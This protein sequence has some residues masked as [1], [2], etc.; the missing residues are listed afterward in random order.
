MRSVGRACAAIQLVS[1]RLRHASS[2]PFTGARCPSLYS[3]WSATEER[4]AVEVRVPTKALTNPLTSEASESTPNSLRRPWKFTHSPKFPYSSPE[5][6]TAGLLDRLPEEALAQIASHGISNASP[7]QCLDILHAL[8][9]LGE[10]LLREKAVDTPTLRRVGAW[11]DDA[12]I[13]FEEDLGQGAGR[14]W[15]HHIQCWRFQSDCYKGALPEAWVYPSFNRRNTLM[16]RNGS[17]S[18]YYRALLACRAYGIDA[19]QVLHAVLREWDPSGEESNVELIQMAN[20]IIQESPKSFPGGPVTRTLELLANCRRGRSMLAFEVFQQMKRDGLKIC[21]ISRAR[22]VFA[23]VEDNCLSQAQEILSVT[24][25]SKEAGAWITQLEARLAF[26]AR[27]QD[28]G[29][30]G[31]T[32]EKVVKYAQNPKDHHISWLLEANIGED[33]RGKVFD[34]FDT[35][36][37][38]PSQRKPQAQHYTPLM[39]ALARRG[40]VS[41]LRGCLEDALRDGVRPDSAMFNAVLSA[42][43]ERQD[44]QGTSSVCLLMEEY[45]VRRTA[46]TY[47]ILVSMS[48]R[49]EG[50]STERV[51]VQAIEKGIELDEQLPNSV[52]HNLLRIGTRNGAPFQAILSFF[53][54]QLPLQGQSLAAQTYTSMIRAACEVGRMEDAAKLLKEYEDGAAGISQRVDWSPAVAVMT[55]YLEA[56]HYRRAH[57]VYNHMRAAGSPFNLELAQAAVTLCVAK[58]TEG[59]VLAAEHLLNEVLQGD[60][61]LKRA[62]LERVLLPLMQA[63]AE[64]LHP[65]DV[66]R[67]FQTLLRKGKPSIG[68]CSIQLDAYR[69]VGDI[70]SA[71]TCWQRIFDQAVEQRSLSSDKIAGTEKRALRPDLLGVPLN[72]ILDTLSLAGEHGELL[73]LWEEVMTS[74]FA[75]SIANRN[76]LIVALIRAGEPEQA[77]RVAEEIL[78]HPGV[79]SPRRVANPH[80]TC[81]D[82]TRF[83][84]NAESSTK[85]VPDVVSYGWKAPEV[86][87][88]A[89]IRARASGTSTRHISLGIHAATMMAMRNV[90]LR[91]QRGHIASAIKPGRLMPDEETRERAEASRVLASLRRDFP[92]AAHVASQKPNRYHRNRLAESDSKLGRNSDRRW[93]RRHERLAVPEEGPGTTSPGRA[94]QG[95]TRSRSQVKELLKTKMKT[96]I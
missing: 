90:L 9:F 2:G 11:M 76:S 95:R 22:L 33:G 82:S 93:W 45:G 70:T 28:A 52:L 24:G 13:Q 6:W 79:E 21:P 64:L 47:S 29:A 86:S 92:R 23:L 30:A 40:D 57:A 81:P 12:L 39:I 14:L 3:T 60:A 15:R 94:K 44:D 67:H 19:M 83:S 43:T 72:M 25:F 31:A 89:D 41:K 36:F 54:A 73:R 69:R 38:Q 7:A 80:S 27:M 35:F 37:R 4:L 49:H 48:V 8:G 88:E 71:R 1:R 68:A 53:R 5:S 26:Y 87:A 58:R 51:L 10:K 77:F 50:S 55:G 84:T 75:P 34:T 61:L 17:L 42:T 18:S 46:E 74:G 96:A 56:G 78:E 20:S 16:A 59:G 85:T 63:H 32:F 65:A 66:E 91:L 62:Q